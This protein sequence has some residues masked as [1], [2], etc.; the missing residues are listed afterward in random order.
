MCLD[1]NHR[2]R[3]NPEMSGEIANV[4]REGKL[5][6]YYQETQLKRDSTMFKNAKNGLSDNGK[7]LILMGS[8]HVACGGREDKEYKSLGS[9]LQED[10]NIRSFTIN[11]DRDLDGDPTNTAKKK[12]PDTN[13]NSV[14][15]TAMEKQEDW[16]GQRLGI[17]LNE[18]ILKGEE[19]K[20]EKFPFD[21]YIKL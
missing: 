13:L 15:F 11:L 19:Y 4:R 8:A 9:F 14:L 3:T 1:S 16:K 17:D 20:K 10:Q 5:K 18:N 2:V 7:M 12:L 21:G 6:E